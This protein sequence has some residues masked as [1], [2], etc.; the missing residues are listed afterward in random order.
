MD[1]GTIPHRRVKG[2]SDALAKLVAIASRQRH[3]VLATVSGGLPYVSL[4]AFALTGDGRGILFATPRGT[5]KYRNLRKNPSV[6]LLIDTR[7]NSSR[8]YLGAESVAVE[9]RAT[10]L[11][12]GRRRGEL[13]KALCRAHPRLRSF[14][15]DPTTALVFV[16]VMQ[17]VH[18]GRFQEVSVWKAL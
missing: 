4:V 14:V 7:S 12:R 3:A 13:A 11:R 18:V 17:V 6:S 8:D 9:G 15:A 5:R 10:P 16:E 2:D 1:E